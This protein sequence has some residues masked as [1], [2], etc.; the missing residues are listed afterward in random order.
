MSRARLE[1]VPSDLAEVKHRRSLGLLNHGAFHR[2][3]PYGAEE[4]LVFIN[5]GVLNYFGIYFMNTL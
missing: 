2:N 5:R 4:L 1:G 3:A